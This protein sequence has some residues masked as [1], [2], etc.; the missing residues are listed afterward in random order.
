MRYQRTTR[1]YLYVRSVGRTCRC[2]RV[3]TYL[4]LWLVG[5]TAAADTMFMLSRFVFYTIKNIIFS[6]VCF[7][8]G[9]RE[10]A[11]PWYV[12]CVLRTHFLLVVCTSMCFV[13]LI[14][15]PGTGI[16]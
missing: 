14:P 13:V 1:T 8:A 6:C 7:R 12:I 5:G 3:E 15:V 4:S 9:F 11:V 10:F 2:L 16:L